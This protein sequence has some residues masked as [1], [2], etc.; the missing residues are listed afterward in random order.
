MEGDATREGDLIE[1]FL[2]LNDRREGLCGRSGN[3]SGNDWKG[4]TCKD[5]VR[6][7]IVVAATGLSG[8]KGYVCKGVLC[9]N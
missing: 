8:P 5:P 1:D 9:I 2:F 7:V 3:R 4:S 6:G